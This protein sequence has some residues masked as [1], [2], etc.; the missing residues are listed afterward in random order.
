MCARLTRNVA[1][2]LQIGACDE[3]DERRR[4]FTS[5]GF[6]ARPMWMKAQRRIRARERPAGGACTD[7][8]K[9]PWS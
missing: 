1:P 8:A 3:N 6:I 5:R 9:W 4:E 2:R 7:E